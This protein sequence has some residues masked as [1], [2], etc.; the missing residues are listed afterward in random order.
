M[1]LNTC[2]LSG[3]NLTRPVI[4]K[5]N[6]YQKEEIEKH[7]LKTGQCPITGREMKI[8]D[9]VEIKCHEEISLLQNQN[10]SENIPNIFKKDEADKF[11]EEC[12][13]LLERANTEL[14][15]I[16][17]LIDLAL[18]SI[19]KVK[20]NDL[21][22]LI[23]YKIFSRPVELL[24]EGV[25]IIKFGL[26]WRTKEFL[27]INP[28]SDRNL[29]NI[30]DA[31]IKKLNFQDVEGFLT[32]LQE[33][34]TEEN[35]KVFK[36][37]HFENMRILA[38]YFQNQGISKDLCRKGAMDFIGLYEFMEII[39]KYVDDYKNKI[40]PILIELEKAKINMQ[41]RSRSKEEDSQKI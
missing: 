29:Y 5:I 20:K 21:E 16:R 25:L 31:V 18:S 40:D 33:I 22:N 35:L 32:D 14:E 1:N 28:Q 17:P 12:K 38:D 23:K 6:G 27:T 2:N 11:E 19:K 39:I 7:I 26:S 15:Q 4:D 30:R 10:Y 13:Y 9:L 36:V 37:T 34:C 3:V 8:E 41:I 24:L